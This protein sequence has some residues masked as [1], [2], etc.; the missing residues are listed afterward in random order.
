MRTSITHPL[1]IAEIEIAPGYGRIGITL[2]P[3]KKQQHAAS[4][5]W[6][7]D[8]ALD[9]D[10]IAAWNAAAV[11]TLVEKH[12]LEQLGVTGLGEAVEARH[13]NW[14]YFPMKDGGTPDPLFSGAWG[15]IGPELHALLRDGF[16][17][18]IHCKGGLGRAG[19]IAAEL[20]VEL[21]MEHERAVDLVR[22]VRPGAIENDVQRLYVQHTRSCA[23]PL[24]GR[25]ADDIADRAMG[26]LLGLA[27]GDALGT[28]LEFAK[29]DS[30]PRLRDM[31]GGGPFNLQPGQWTDDTAMALALGDSL[32][33][34]PTLDEADLMERFVRWHREGAYS[35][36]GAC[37]DIGITTRLALQRYRETGIVHAGSSDPRS[38]G[39]G[40]LMRL[41]PVAMRHWQDRAMLRD[42]AAR[43]SRTTHGAA[44]A[45]DACTAFAE[46]LADGIAGYPRSQVMRVREGA[47][48]G[49][50]AT[51]MTGSWRGK[52]RS[53]IA[54]TG[55]VAHSLE[56]AL[57]C[58]GRT[59]SFERAV[60]M[61]ANLGDDADTTAAITGQLAGV[62]YGADAIPQAW[63]DMMAWGDRIEA[64]GGALVE[65]GQE[66]G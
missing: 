12:E 47:W 29:R 44:E 17:V 45:I 42:V 65:A 13:M 52:S 39:N 4:G 54:S 9:L 63:R 18:L 64:M 1:H 26:A 19:T 57:W 60:L 20:L 50:I 48:S 33:A 2:C 31:T 61:A 25:T 32:L 53:S 43:Q 41:A 34:C 55:Y 28:T 58:V 16:N 40:S 10:A 62:L 24:P 21:G 11:V 36:T 49:N 30:K 59:S 5:G 37:F 22:E 7:R 8:L 51:I 46:A 23:E 35:C 6:E 15:I 56:A 38:A 66:P 3:G 27:I 14:W